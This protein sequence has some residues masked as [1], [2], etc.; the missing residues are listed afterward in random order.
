MKKQG[1]Q[2]KL[3]GTSIYASFS[4]H[5]KKF[6][7]SVNISVESAKHF[8][9]SERTL[10]RAHRGY[11]QDNEKLFNYE[12]KVRNWILEAEKFNENTVD[13]VKNKFFEVAN[14]SKSK[15]KNHSLDSL[16]YKILNEVIQSDP[17]YID[18]IN[19]KNRKTAFDYTAVLKLV[20]DYEIG[21]NITIQLK[22]LSYQLV[23]RIF[24]YHQSAFNQYLGNYDDALKYD[25][26][27]INKSGLAL[28]TLHN[29]W[30]TFKK[31]LRFIDQGLVNLNANIFNYKIK[32]GEVKTP[33][34]YNY[35]EFAALVNYKPRPDEVNIHDLIIVSFATGLNYNDIC[36]LK[37]HNFERVQNYNRI[38]M[39]RNKS[40]ARCQIPLT[41]YVYNI[42]KKYNFT[43]DSI[44]NHTFN[45][46]LRGIF[47][48]FPIFDK[49]DLFHQEEYNLL[50][51]LTRSQIL[52]HENFRKTFITYCFDLKL[53]EDKIRKRVGHSDSRMMK[54]YNDS[55]ERYI[56]VEIMELI[57]K[58]IQ[59]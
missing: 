30:I 2:F 27:K 10:T 54:H 58:V 34:I 1:F 52:S 21:N 4:D 50:L 40:K 59:E 35:K 3:R 56:E 9:I 41:D 16:L 14:I 29:R 33:V 18:S 37:V 20:R 22:E 7:E 46:K 51:P 13:F 28:T 45:E 49:V 26:M 39:R 48:N 8:S 38:I 6:Y 12:T 5:G 57:K 47:S 53:S 15:L 17:T 32:K 24:K 44:K 36:D 43:M 55:E 42:F 11:L 19:K 23:E 25:K 31:L